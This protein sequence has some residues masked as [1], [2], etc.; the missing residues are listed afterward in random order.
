[1]F[2]PR[3]R[4]HARLETPN[5]TG[6]IMTAGEDARL[7][8]L[9]A[10]AVA[11][12]LTALGVAA[13]VILGTIRAGLNVWLTVES[14]ERYLFWIL[15]VYLSREHGGAQDF[16]LHDTAQ[17]PVAEGKATGDG[18][19]SVVAINYTVTLASVTTASGCALRP[20]IMMSDGAYGL[21]RANF[22][23]L[24]NASLA[25]FRIPTATIA[26]APLLPHYDDPADD[27]DP[28]SYCGSMAPLSSVETGIDLFASSLPSIRRAHHL[29]ARPEGRDDSNGG[30]GPSD[31]HHQGNTGTMA[32]GRIGGLKRHD[33]VNMEAET[34]DR[35]T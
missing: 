19:R 15:L 9:V 12:I 34:T 31:G 23:D 14:E 16:G 24:L 20:G 7:A 33:I 4:E 26:H 22:N 28:M 10:T 29:M 5:L 11:L 8:P 32:I 17:H 18:Q 6:R 3:L 35:E 30:S 27:N 25:I 1:M 21:N 13:A 2:L